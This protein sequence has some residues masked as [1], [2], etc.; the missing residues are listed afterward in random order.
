VIHVSDDGY[1]AN[2]RSQSY[3]APDTTLPQSGRFTA[4]HA[5]TEAG[6]SSAAR[7]RSKDGLSDKCL[8]LIPCAAAST[9]SVAISG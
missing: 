7:F 6:F 5:V 3:L 9:S 2:G 4:K 1:I 8:Q